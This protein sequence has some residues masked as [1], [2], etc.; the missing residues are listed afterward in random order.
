MD[1]TARLRKGGENTTR[2]VHNQEGGVT[3]PPYPQTIVINSIN[4][5]NGAGQSIFDITITQTTNQVKNGFRLTCNAPLGGANYTN[6]FTLSQLNN[7]ANTLGTLP[8]SPGAKYDCSVVPYTI[9]PATTHSPGNIHTFWTAPPPPTGIA[10]ASFQVYPNDPTR[11]TISWTPP[12]LAVN[13]LPGYITGNG[14][15]TSKKVGPVGTV[16]SQ[17]SI[18]LVVYTIVITPDGGTPF[19][20]NT[21]HTTVPN[22]ATN[23]SGLTRG[24]TNTIRMK[25]G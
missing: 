24:V 11:P 22:T 3:V 8:L 19:E 10:L 16:S 5:N 20:I 15:G 21:V 9:N 25:T 6:D 17:M 13:L 7:G 4:P 1:K 14:S 12:N 2:K 23:V 18:V